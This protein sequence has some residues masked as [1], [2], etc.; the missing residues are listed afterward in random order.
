V[1]QHSALSP[2]LGFTYSLPLHNVLNG[3]LFA[4][5]TGLS[6]LTEIAISI[7]SERWVLNP[8]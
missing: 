8:L 2:Q 7:L 4:K 6:V 1:C 3:P 5:E